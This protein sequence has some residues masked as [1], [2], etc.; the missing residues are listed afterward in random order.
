[1]RLVWL[2]ISLASV[3]TVPAPDRAGFGA[4]Q[5]PASTQLVYATAVNADKAAIVDLDPADFVVKEDGKECTV[6]AVE[7][8]EQRRCRSRFSSM[9]TVRASS[10]S[11]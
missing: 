8:C 11:D 3:A 4:G 9:T 1:M 5:T 10:A 2:A 7:R 6:I